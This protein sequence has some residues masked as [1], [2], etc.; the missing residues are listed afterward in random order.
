MKL[1][2]ISKRLSVVCCW[3]PTRNGFKHE[4]TMLINGNSRETAKVCYINR[5][6]ESFQ[7]QT[8]MQTLLDKIIH[9]DKKIYTAREIAKFRKLLKS[10][11]L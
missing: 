1:F 6:W 7:Y 5:T 2:K 4:A 9:D 3:K 8:V 11:Q 10:N